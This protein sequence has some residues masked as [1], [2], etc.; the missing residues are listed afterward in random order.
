MVDAPTPPPSPEFIALMDQGKQLLKQ[1]LFDQALLVFQQAQQIDD[2]R[3]EL[4]EAI[5]ATYA[6]SGNLESAIEHYRRVTLLAPRKSVAFVNL[7]ALYNRIGDYAKAV[8]SC[9]KAVQVDRKSADGYYNLGIAHRKL[10]QLPLALPA[11]REAI[12]LKPKMIDAHYNLGNVFLDMGNAREA[13]HHFK[14]AI[15]IDPE[16]AKAK[17]GLEKAEQLKIQGKVTSSPFGRLVDAN[18][19]VNQADELDASKMKAL[20]DDDREQDHHMLKVLDRSIARAAKDLRDQLRLKLVPE[21]KELD[22]SVCSSVSFQETM[23][24]FKPIATNF[25][26]ACRNLQAAV[27]ELRDHEERML[28]KQRK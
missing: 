6:M 9:R 5:A 25:Q 2:D 13:I 26:T 3:P 23:I 15:A 28:A 19:A 24:K 18:A 1:R 22:R 7:G 14:E 10:N 20:S 12:R 11:Y 4:H 21:I 16:F 27:Q 8:E 17:V